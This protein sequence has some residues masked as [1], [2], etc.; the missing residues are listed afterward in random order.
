[1]IYMLSVVKKDGEVSFSKSFHSTEINVEVDRVKNSEGS[2][3][4]IAL[5]AD[6]TNNHSD[7]LQEIYS[8]FK[9]RDL[10]NIDV[11]NDE[12]ELLYR[13]ITNASVDNINYRV[14]N[15]V[16]RV[17]GEDV[18]YIGERVILEII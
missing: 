3:S 18:P 5:E 11:C 12:H 6:I 9:V 7:V 8:A 1:M 13:L 17:S 4:T 2:I 10:V 16:K 15:S 14:D